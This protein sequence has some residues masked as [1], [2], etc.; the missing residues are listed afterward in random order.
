MR[1]CPA[2]GKWTLDF[3]EYFGRFRCYSPECGWMPA[4]TAE[5]ELS[6][7][8]AETQPMGLNVVP[9][10][11]L[12]LT[13]T[14]SY[15]NENDALSVDLGLDEPTFDLPEP[16]GRMIWKIGYQTERVAGF[17]ILGAK[18]WRVSTLK[19]DLIARR[20]DEIEQG[21]RRIPGLLESG[22]VTKDV[23]EQVVVTAFSECQPAHDRTS[24]MDTALKQV[25][26]S[27][28]KLQLV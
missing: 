1:K 22:R 2:C 21:L 24:P 20:Y 10:P 8:G 16:D 17:T 27:F 15:D 4:S 23:L 19:I 28:E 13:V 9:I 25:I 18:R 12:G 7:L 26:D 6:L 14:S 3:D 11:E 5:R